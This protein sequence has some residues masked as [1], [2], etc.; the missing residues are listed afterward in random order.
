MRFPTVPAF[1]R[2]AVS[3]SCTICRC[4]VLS[5]SRAAFFASGPEASS[6]ACRLYNSKEKSDIIGCIKA[7]REYIPTH[8]LLRTDL[9]LGVVDLLA[10]LVQLEINYPIHAINTLDVNDGIRF[11]ARFT[12]SS[13][14]ATTSSTISVESPRLRCDSRIDSAFPPFLSM[15]S[16]TSSVMARDQSW[17][18]SGGASFSFYELKPSQEQ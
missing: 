7:H 13:Y 3:A 16:S 17:L 9:L 11:G 10:E 14:M 8:L 5:S 6:F 4:L 15:N 1:V 18:W 2:I 12:H